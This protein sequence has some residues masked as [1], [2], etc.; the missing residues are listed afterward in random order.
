MDTSMPESPPKHTVPVRTPLVHTAPAP[1]RQAH[2][3]EHMSPRPI[4]QR[5]NPPFP[6]PSPRSCPMEA[7]EKVYHTVLNP[8]G[9]QI[10]SDTG[11]PGY[12]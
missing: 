4:H 7:P 11:E 10:K 3:W 1:S 8:K 6:C 2:V 5:S 9:L 12:Y